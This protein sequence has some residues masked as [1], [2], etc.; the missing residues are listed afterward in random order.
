MIRTLVKR[1]RGASSLPLVSPA[2]LLLHL[3]R[4]AKFLS[5]S[6]TADLTLG[7]GGAITH[8]SDPAKEWDEVLTKLDAVLGRTA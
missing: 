1:G 7:A 8:L 2:R 4:T 5:L 6:P 3:R